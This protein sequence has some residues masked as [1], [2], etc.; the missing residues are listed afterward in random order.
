[1]GSL[2]PAAQ[3]PSGMCR[4][5]V[6]AARVRVKHDP[7]TIIPT[8]EM[9][10]RPSNC[11]MTG[12]F[13]SVS[14]PPCPAPGCFS[15]IRIHQHSNPPGIRE[16]IM[17]RKFRAFS[18]ESI[19]GGLEAPCLTCYVGCRVSQESAYSVA[20]KKGCLQSPEA[21]PCPALC[22][23]GGWC[24]KWASDVLSSQ[25][26]HHQGHTMA[27]DWYRAWNYARNCSMKGECLHSGF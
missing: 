12:C 7:A 4:E 8:L 5:Q 27:S 15:M 21:Q 22:P 23:V 16:L 24:Q 14:D 11:C 10:P 26:C 20:P 6:K 19:E 9:P 17:K 3:M 25:G 2:H 13:S 1:M 18:G